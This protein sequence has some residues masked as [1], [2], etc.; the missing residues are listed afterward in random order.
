MLS[1][2]LDKCDESLAADLKNG[3]LKRLGSCLESV[4]KQQR[5][6]GWAQA[7]S[8]TCWL[9]RRGKQGKKSDSF[10]TEHYDSDVKDVIIDAQ[11]E[12]PGKVGS[13]S[14]SNFTVGHI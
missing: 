7:P 4:G 14:K 3:Y 8:M 11:T 2:W 5:A 1:S 9:C 10:L 13:T 6:G 12:D